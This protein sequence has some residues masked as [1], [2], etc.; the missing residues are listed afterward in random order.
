[1]KQCSVSGHRMRMYK[2][3]N[4]HITSSSAVEGL[5]RGGG[6]R[7]RWRASS[8]EEG[9]V[10]GHGHAR[11]RGTGTRGGGRTRK[12]RAAVSRKANG[13][14]REEEEG[15]GVR[16]GRRRADRSAP[17]AGGYIPERI[18]PGASHQPGVKGLYSRCE[19]P[20][21]SKGFFLAGHETAAHLYS[22][23]GFPPGSKGGLQF[24]FPPVLSR[25]F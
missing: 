23:V 4:E 11:R 19:L 12:K 25:L 8:A 24:H 9:A 16:R 10:E 18:T 1:M 13:R 15:G 3:I 21:G 17:G 22:R 6:P 7:A 20:T 14:R 5:G 2:E